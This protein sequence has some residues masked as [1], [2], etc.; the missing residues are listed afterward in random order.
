MPDLIADAAGKQITLELKVADERKVSELLDDLEHQLL[1]D[2]M[3]D[4]RSNFGLFVVMVRNP[5][6][7]FPHKGRRLGVPQLRK[8]LQS[9]SDALSKRSMGRNTVA[10]VVF[11]LTEDTRAKSRR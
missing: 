4:V 1:N 5:N 9:R 11:A 2:Y 7:Q 6:K 3:G 8:V 10:V